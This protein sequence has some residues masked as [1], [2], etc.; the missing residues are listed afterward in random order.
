MIH[1]SGK[2]GESRGTCGSS[3]GLGRRLALFYPSRSVFN[4]TKGFAS[5]N[6]NPFMG[7]EVTFAFTALPITTYALHVWVVLCIQHSAAG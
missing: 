5:K 6:R 3:H 7:H 2:E 1:S 4:P